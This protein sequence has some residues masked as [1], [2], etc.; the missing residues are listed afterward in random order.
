MPEPSDSGHGPWCAWSDLNRQ[1]TDHFKGSRY[2]EFATRTWYWTSVTLRAAPSCKGGG[3]TSCSRPAWSRASGSNTSTDASKASSF[4]RRTRNSAPLQ[5]RGARQRYDSTAVT[6]PRT[7]G[8][9]LHFF[10]RRQ[11]G[12]H[13]TMWPASFDAIAQNLHI[14]EPPYEVRPL[15]SIHCPSPRSLKSERGD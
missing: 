1:M 13:I 15:A 4:T 10:R 3:V 9:S 8:P 2:A 6:G 12:R 5:G 7:F 11:H 14:G